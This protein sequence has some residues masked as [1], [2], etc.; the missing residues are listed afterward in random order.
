[1]T[2][3]ILTLKQL[4]EAMKDP[5]IK[6]I[7]EDRINCPEMQKITRRSKLGGFTLVKK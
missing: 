6:A 3:K 7:V 2:N 1:M 5:I 4:K